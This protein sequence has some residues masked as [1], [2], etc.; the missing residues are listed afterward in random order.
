MTL[1]KLAN[2]YL[3]YM[4]KEYSIHHNRYFS[5][6]DEL[7]SLFPDEDVEFICDA[8]RKL[9][10]DGFVKNEWADNKPYII[11][12]NIDAIVQAEE[13]T[14]LRKIYNFLKEVREWI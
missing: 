7:C 8:F 3:E 4:V 12:L 9:S 14:N 11:T 5:N 6:F 13:N 1:T 10:H 2:A